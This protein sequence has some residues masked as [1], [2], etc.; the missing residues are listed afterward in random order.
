MAALGVAL[1]VVVIW[2]GLKLMKRIVVGLILLVVAAALFFGMHF[3]DF[4]LG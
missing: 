2:V 4:A 1:I 3:G